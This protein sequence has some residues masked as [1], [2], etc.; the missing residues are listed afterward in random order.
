MYPPIV[1]EGV[2]AARP[3]AEMAGTPPIDSEDSDSPPDAAVEGAPLTSQHAAILIRSISL[4][5]F[6]QWR[7]PTMVGGL[8][9]GS[10]I[11]FTACSCC[12]VSKAYVYITGGDTGE[13]SDG[14]G[15]V[16]DAGDEQADKSKSLATSEDGIKPVLRHPNESDLTERVTN[17]PP[18]YAVEPLSSEER[19]G[20]LVSQSYG[21]MVGATQID[22]NQ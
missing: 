13:A 4:F 17:R 15:T 3:A 8:H 18:Q 6:K 21:V 9:S 10:S 16:E 7:A 5:S 20:G 12:L 14:M 1:L 2:P 11:R 22:G 19:G